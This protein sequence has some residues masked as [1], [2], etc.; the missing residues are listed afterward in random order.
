MKSYEEIIKREIVPTPENVHVNGKAVFGTFDKE[1]PKMDFLDIE[2]PVPHLP[3]CLKR[4]KLTLWEAVEVN[5]EDGVLLAAP[6]NMGVFGT[7][8]LLFYDKKEKKVYK[9]NGNLSAK[10]TN[11]SAT[12]LGGDVSEAKTANLHI[13]VTNF[14]E[15]GRAVVEGRGKGKSGEISYK[16]ELKRVSVPCV[17]SIPFG[18]N[19]PLYFQKDF[20]KASGSLT[21]NGKTYDSTDTTT[22]IIDDHRGYY[23][24]K[25]HYDW[26]T[27]MGI[28]EHN[29]EKK[30]LA[31]NLTRNQSL[32]QDKYNENLIWFEN[33]CSL[34][35]PV[36][37]EH[38]E[39]NV[40]HVTDE[41]G[42][43]DVTFNIGD[44]YA[45][46]VHALVIK[47]DY[48]VT[49]GEMKGF[50]TDKNGEKYVLDGMVG[51][52]EDKSLLF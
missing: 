16:F 41:H 11:I 13:K 12:L 33:D 40:W 27:T 2:K 35:P 45:M 50:V 43:V 23:P 39:E 4:F 34:L 5:L 1:F 10:K 48:F 19:R 20:F 32:D 37:F 47:I 18:E 51:I 30:Y 44:R 38:V 9:W 7:M 21:F 52:G 6:C 31:I 25:A 28:C 29:G 17:V 46:L 24:R 3:D 14:F 36:K 26:V 42:M 49:F 8:L 15:E 22:A